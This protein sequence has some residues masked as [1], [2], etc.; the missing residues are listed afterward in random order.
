MVNAHKPGSLKLCLSQETGLFALPHDH[1]ETVMWWRGKSRAP[2][3][4]QSA[5]SAK[6]LCWQLSM[7]KH[8]TVPGL[9]EGHILQIGFQVESQEDELSA[10]RLLGYVPKG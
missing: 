3:P 10:K 5:L 9:A 1:K 4:R 2:F 8:C 7:Q 6:R